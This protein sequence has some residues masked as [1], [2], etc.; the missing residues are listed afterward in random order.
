MIQPLDD[1]DY[2]ALLQ[3]DT[4]VVLYKH[5]H[6]CPVSSGA[7]RRLEGFAETHPDVPVYEVNVIRQRALSMQIADDFDVRHES[8]QVFLVVDGRAVWHT[9]HG[10]ITAQAVE[11]ALDEA[12]QD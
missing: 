7:Q 2:P 3:R 4:P 1:A 9:S 5:S 10:R 8:P 6:R 12:A 11:D